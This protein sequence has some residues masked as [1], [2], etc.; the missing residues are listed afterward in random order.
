MDD[1]G[2]VDRF[3]KFMSDAV[4]AGTPEDMFI[5]NAILSVAFIGSSFFTFGWT[6]F[7]LMFTLLFGT[8][9][10]LR[11]VSKTVDNYWPLA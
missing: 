10:I 11:M 3:A 2:L 6:L 8:I 1:T 4:G 7:L 9:A 5:A